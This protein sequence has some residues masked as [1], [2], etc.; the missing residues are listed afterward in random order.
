MRSRVSYVCD[1][2]FVDA[3]AIARNHSNDGQT[4]ADREALRKAC[5]I[6]QYLKK[7]VQLARHCNGLT[8]TFKGRQVVS[9]KMKGRQVISL[10]M[11]GRQ[12]I[13]S[14]VKGRQESRIDRQEEILGSSTEAWGQKR[15]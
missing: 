14:K 8:T 15:D 12:V 6:L 10:K 7:M 11:K 9:S 2:P 1:F 4:M 3:H 13:I 5:S